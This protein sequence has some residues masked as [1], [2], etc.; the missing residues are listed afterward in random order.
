MLFINGTIMTMSAETIENGYVRTQ[1]GKITNL[2]EMAQSPQAGEGEEVVDLAG[3]FLLP[4]FID[5][6]TH[7]GLEEDGQGDEGD[8]INEM[9]E[10]VSPHLRAIDGIN[11]FDRCFREY[12]EAG[13]TTAVISPGSANPL[14]GQICAVKTIGRWVEEMV[15]AQPL[16]MKL[17]LG[18]NPKMLYGDKSLSPSNRMTTAAII[19]ENFYKAQKYKQDKERAVE[20]GETLPDYDARCEAL[21]PVLAGQMQVHIH[22]HRAYDIL[23]GVRL[24]KEFGLDYVLVHCTEGHMIADI[25]GELKAKVICGPLIGARTK[26]ELSNFHPGNCK[27]LADA[28]V[29]LAICSD[30]PEVPGH[31]LSYSVALACRAG[32]SRQDALRALTIHAAEVV[33]LSDRLGSIAVGKDAD[34]LIF[35]GH[36]LEGAAEPEMVFIGGKRIHS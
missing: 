19:R 31:L 27:A 25:L 1:G 33:G 2:G 18:E 9:T 5:A 28:G 36:P 23:T 11:P 22:A 16:A 6:H 4:G 12:R 34:L 7:L 24:A 10:P 29:K 13:V 35:A 20:E 14:G 8:D 26:P 32:L 30:H 17:A 3:R 15:V 21:L